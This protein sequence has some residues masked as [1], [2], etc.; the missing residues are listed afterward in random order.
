[1]FS[2][3]RINEDG[4]TTTKGRAKESEM[5]ERLST[6][7]IWFEEGVRLNCGEFMPEI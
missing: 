7:K 5:K 4:S 2:E 6:E 3:L 1:M